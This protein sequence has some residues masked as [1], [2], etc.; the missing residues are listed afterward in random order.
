M[1]WR[2]GVHSVIGGLLVEHPRC[3]P[4]QQG[5]TIHGGL[6]TATQIAAV[7]AR[8]IRIVIASPRFSLPNMIGCAH[9]PRRCGPIT[10]P[11]ALTSATGTL[12]GIGSFDECTR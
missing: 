12:H 3:V 6:P 2:A 10:Q 4:T 9:Y 7:A 1:T 5:R 8:R 11:E